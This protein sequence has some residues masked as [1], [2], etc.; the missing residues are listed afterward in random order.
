MK[1]PKL[2]KKNFIWLLCCGGFCLAALALFLWRGILVGKQES[3]QMAERWSSDGGVAQ[4]SC[5]FSENAGMTEDRIISFEHTLDSVLKEA[6]IQTE[7]ENEGAR[8][9]VDAYS[10][11]GMLTV[12][13]QRAALTVNALGVGGDFF[14][15]HPQKLLYGG[16]FSGSDLNQDG[17]I[18][19]EEIAWQ[20]FGANDIVGQIISVGGTPHI[21]VGVIERPQ[22]KME[23]GAGLD[24]PIAYVSFSTLAAQGQVTDVNHYEI[25]MPNPIKDFAMQKVKENLYADENETEFIENTDRYSFAASFHVLGQFG[26]RSMNGK[27]IVYPYW[28]NLARGYEDIIALITL[29]ITVCLAVPGVTAVVWLIFWWKHKSWTFKSLWAKLS[30]RIRSLREKGYAK[31]AQK[32]KSQ[33]QKSQKQKVQKQKFLTKKA[34]KDESGSGPALA[35][36]HETEIDLDETERN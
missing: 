19:D 30:D 35:E 12:S 7:S 13:N 10:A 5:F 22:G 11:P 2:S 25:V 31:K 32:Q 20:L 34:R 1:K 36:A 21:I 33:K 28:E 27:A 23:E 4:I 24:E 15:F 17:I 3:Q 6:S 29:I 18:I 8:L 14:L 9:W 16:Y 26:Y